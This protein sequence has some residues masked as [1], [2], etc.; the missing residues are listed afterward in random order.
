MDPTTAT[1]F[2]QVAS[3]DPLNGFVPGD[4]NNSITGNPAAL[5]AN[6]TVLSLVQNP[7][8]TASRLQPNTVSAKRALP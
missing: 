3:G 5:T 6:V 2:V 7:T 4:K 1:Y 8:S